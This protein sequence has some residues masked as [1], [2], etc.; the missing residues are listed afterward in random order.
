MK[1]PLLGLVAVLFLPFTQAT[2]AAERWEVLPPTPAGV[3]PDK[4]GYAAVN[5]IRLYYEVV[6]QGSPVLLLHPGLANSD[7]WSGQARSLSARHKVIVVD[8]RGHGRSSRDGKPFSYDLMADD[9][10]ALLDVLKIAKVDVV[11]WSDGA[12]IGLDLAIR[13]PRRV[14][15]IFAFGAN[16]TPDGLVP[17]VE[18]SPA[19]VAYF[20]RVGQEYA[21]LSPTPNEFGTFLA[22]I[23]KMWNSEPNWS[24]AQLRSIRSLVWVVAGDH[25]EAIRRSHLEHI[26]ATIPGAGLLILPNVGHFAPL[27]DR[28]LFN[29]AILQFLDG[30]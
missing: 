4:T 9:V 22:Q 17:G 30:E 2:L 19:F 1:M 28:E 15:K 3:T 24:D 11:G 16:T 25:E 18:K 14:G 12:I 6:G 26:A 29:A 21:K 20:A 27:Q 8:S 23:G 10:V 5:G 7:W 13:Y